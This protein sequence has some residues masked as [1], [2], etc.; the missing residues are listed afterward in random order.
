MKIQLNRHCNKIDQS[1]LDKIYWNNNA[2]VDGIDHLYSNG[3]AE[4][5]QSW[6][7]TQKIL[8]IRL[9]IKDQK[10]IQ[11]NGHHPTHLIIFVHNC[12]QCLSKLAS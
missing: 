8:S 5:L 7:K 12:T 11:A 6:I 4:F 3:E 1:N 9:S 10:P 2:L